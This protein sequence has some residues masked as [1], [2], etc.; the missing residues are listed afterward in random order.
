MVSAYVLCYFYQFSSN[1]PQFCLQTSCCHSGMCSGTAYT[2]SLLMMA[3]RD[4]TSSKWPLSRDLQV[5]FH[6][7]NFQPSFIVSQPWTIALMPHMP[8]NVN[9][10]YGIA[11]W[12]LGICSAP[13]GV[14]HTPCA[15]KVAFAHTWLRLPWRH[16]PPLVFG[17]MSR[18]DGA[19]G[20][21]SGMYTCVQSLWKEAQE[22][23]MHICSVA[24]AIPNI[25]AGSYLVIHMFARS[26][27][28][29]VYLVVQCVFMLR[30]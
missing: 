6:L 10:L 8:L 25:W 3:A 16:H 26:G 15:G 19:A 21:T 17:R 24:L 11:D 5:C 29:Y 1:I 7:S 4:D 27:P 12:V 20:W 2:L 14:R 9:V 18:T 13:D 28:E 30:E 22:Y 23:Q